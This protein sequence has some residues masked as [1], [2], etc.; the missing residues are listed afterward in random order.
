[1]SDSARLTAYKKLTKAG[2]TIGL[3]YG[4][5]FTELLFAVLVGQLARQE[6]NDEDRKNLLAA[7]ALT[8]T[9]LTV[10]AIIFI[11][12][13]VLMIQNKVATQTKGRAPEELTP[14]EKAE[15]KHCFTDA[16]TVTAASAAIASTTL[17]FAKPIFEATGQ[18]PEVARLTGT[19]LREYGSIAFPGLVFHAVFEQFLLGFQRENHATK[20]IWLNL[21]PFSALAAL[22]SLKAGYKLSGVTY[23]LAASTYT[24]CLMLGAYLG[25]RKE[26]K[27]YHFFTPQKPSWTGIKSLLIDGTVISLGMILEYST[28]LALGIFIGRLGNTELAKWNY[29]G[30]VNLIAMIFSLSTS[31]ALLRNMGA[32]PQNTTQYVKMVSPASL[33][34]ALPVALLTLAYPTIFSPILSEIP[35]NIQLLLGLNIISLVADTLR[36][37][38]LFALRGLGDLKASS[39]ISA[40]G[41]ALAFPAALL[42][43]AYLIPGLNGMVTGIAVALSLTAAALAL[44]VKQKMATAP[45]GENTRLLAQSHDPREESDSNPSINVALPYQAVAAVSP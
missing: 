13:P 17:A 44:R 34:L 11:I 28:Y 24:T 9:T 45:L 42:I 14:D 30:W 15:V 38:N 40:G 21:A 16:I 3:G 20:L 19:M 35:D 32:D 1:M 6:A 22:L 4:F 27:D 25:L 41:V 29:C 12:S 26:F 5:S 33:T 36:N 39:T 7:S 10:F 43:Q 8:L 23:T 2:L 18:H 37:N 31:S